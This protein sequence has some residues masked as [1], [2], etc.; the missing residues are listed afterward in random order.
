[1]ESGHELTRLRD[2]M[3]TDSA[4]PVVAE[5]C[6]QEGLVLVTQNYKDFR[7]IVKQ[8]ELAGD[9]DMLMRIELTC[10]DLNICDRFEAVIDAIE[11]EWERRAGD[12]GGLRVVLGNSNISVFR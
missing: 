5:A 11:Y 2:V 7:R 6:R 9:A 4:D 10:D 1:M 3:L 8:R 12:V